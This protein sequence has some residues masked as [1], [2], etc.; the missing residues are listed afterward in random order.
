[1]LNLN[2]QLSN[3]KIMGLVVKREEATKKEF[4]TAFALHMNV[5]VAN[6]PENSHQFYWICRL[7]KL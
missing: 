3:V 2:L 1:M 7:F 6:V 4:A 5:F